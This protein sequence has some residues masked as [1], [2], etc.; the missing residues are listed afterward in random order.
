GQR[1]VADFL[2]RLVRAHPQM[3]CSVLLLDRYVD[4]VEEGVDVGIRIGAL[5]DSSLVAQRLGQVR[6][7]VV[8]S[9]ALLRRQ[10]VPKHPS[11]LRERPCVRLSGPVRPGWVFHDG[12]RRL[13]VPVDGPLDFNHAGAALRACEDGLGF[14]QFFSYQLDEALAARRLRVV[15][16]DFEPPPLPVSVV[17]PNAR[18]LPARVRAFVEAAQRELAPLFRAR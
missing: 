2:A 13:H 7:S 16:E 15:L 4:L 1:V 10:G 12:G 18:G 8:A 5:D 14:G 6:H 3:R 9:P 11:E 17:Y